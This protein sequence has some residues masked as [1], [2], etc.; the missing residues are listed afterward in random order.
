MHQNK[1]PFC[2]ATVFVILS[3]CSTSRNSLPLATLR[4]VRQAVHGEVADA[5]S[6]TTEAASKTWSDMVHDWN[7][8]ENDSFTEIRNAAGY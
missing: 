6:S 1:S 3:G 2:W 4:N 8:T 7:C 5:V